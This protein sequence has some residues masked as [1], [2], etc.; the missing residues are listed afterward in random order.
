MTS[1][2]LDSNHLSP[3]ITLGHPVREKILLRLTQGDRFVVPTIVLAEF[4]FGMLLLPRVKQNREIWATVSSQV[5]FIST[6]RDDALQSAR[7]R[8]ELRRNGWQLKMPDALIAVLALRNYFT[9]LTT[10]GDF[11]RVPELQIENWHRRVSK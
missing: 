2:L 6:T 5:E 8:V 1:Y 7:L 3:L 11:D 4:M 9:L 10:D